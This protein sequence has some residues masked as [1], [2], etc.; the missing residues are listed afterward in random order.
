MAARLA[1]LAVLIT[2]VSG[3]ATTDP[4]VHHDVQGAV[5]AHPFDGWWTAELG[6]TPRTQFAGDWELTCQDIEGEFAFEVVES[7]A[8]INLLG[9]YVEQPVDSRGR[10][11]LRQGTEYAVTE[12]PSSDESLADGGITLI[13][14]GDLLRSRPRGSLTHHIAEIDAGCRTG[15]AFRREQSTG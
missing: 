2:T 5:I 8:Q 4:V 10:F 9:Q 1:A 12:A 7:V 6:G 15:I 3:C 13:L 11:E 14:K